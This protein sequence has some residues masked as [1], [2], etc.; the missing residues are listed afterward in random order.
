VRIG[1]G[2]R[3]HHLDGPAVAPLRNEDLAQVGARLAVVRVLQEHEAQPPP[4]AE[5]GD[6]LGH[7]AQKAER[8]PVGERVRDEKDGGRGDGATSQHP[9][10]AEVDPVAH[11]PAC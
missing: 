7:A 4:A 11:G 3:L 5:I 2:E 6:R 9:E 1:V 10:D 8:V